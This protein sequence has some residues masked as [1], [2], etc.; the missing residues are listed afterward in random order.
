MA[1][2]QPTSRRARPRVSRKDQRCHP[3]LELLETRT[4]LTGTPVP[5][6]EP[7]DSLN[8]A[9]ALGAL[10]NASATPVQGVIGSGAFGAADVD[11]YT[12]TLTNPGHI[13]LSAT[14]D[15]SAN[16]NAVLGLYNNDPGNTFDPGAALDG[17][18]L[19]QQVV[20][21]GG[22]AT[23]DR[24]LAAGTY[25]IAVSGKGNQYFY[26][27]MPGSGLDGQTGGYLLQATGTP[28]VSSSVL[29][30]SDF[31][32]VTIH[33]TSGNPVLHS[34]PLV[35]HFDASAP[36]DPGSDVHLFDSNGDDLPISVNIDAATDELQIMPVQALAPDALVPGNN[37]YTVVVYT[38]S[39]DATVLF[40]QSFVVDGVEGNTSAIADD[41]VA[42]AHN[43]GDV[44]DGRIVQ[45]TGA[46]GTDPF[47]DPINFFGDPNRGNPTNQVDLYRFHVGGSGNYALVAE[48]FAGRI[49]SSLHPALTLFRLNADGSVDTLAG[50]FETGNTQ[51]AELDVGQTIPRVPLLTDPAIFANL[52]P[53]DYLL[54]VSTRFNY[55]DPTIGR[56]TGQNGLSPTQLVFDP[57]VS[58][59]GTLGGGSVG[60]YVLNL[61]VQPASFQPGVVSV[62]VTSSDTA[63]AY[64][65]DI[66]VRFSGPVNLQ[67]LAF[68]A[69]EHNLPSDLAAIFVQDANGATFVPRLTSYNPNTFDAHFI[70]LDRLPTGTYQLHLSG[71]AGLADFSGNQL[72]GN[73]LGGDFVD[74]F[75]VTGAPALSSPVPTQ[76]GND[77]VAHAQNLGVVF[78]HEFENQ[79]TLR[80][81][82][83]ASPTDPADSSDFYSFQVVQSL[84]YSFFLRNVNGIVL[85]PDLVD[86]SGNILASGSRGILRVHLDPGTYF[87]R[88][89][90]WDSTT[91]A[92]TTYDLVFSLGTNNE[93]P[94]ALTTGPAPALRLQLVSTVA[95]PVPTAPS[96]ITLPVPPGNQNIAVA[97]NNG[98]S[99]GLASLLPGVANALAAGPV[100]GV[101]SPDAVID[102][103]PT[104]VLLDLSPPT[105]VASGSG[106]GR[107]AAPG[108]AGDDEPDNFFSRFAAALYRWSQR[109][110]HARDLLF[111]SDILFRS[112]EPGGIDDQ[113]PQPAPDDPDDGE[114]APLRQVDIEASVPSK[115]DNCSDADLV[116]T[117]VL[118]LTGLALRSGPHDRKAR[119]LA[120]A[121]RSQGDA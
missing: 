73:T 64:P 106:T 50:N 81:D 70:L 40:Q 88:V 8:H 99:S 17:H 114:A 32:A 36:I 18:R 112:P 39:T 22:A 43:L 16:L 87:L 13:H 118:G 77:D 52:T 76:L 97:A 65:T 110:L 68:A 104:V 37:P 71:A 98:A 115:V 34:S 42:N 41:T 69:F 5:E 59:S 10:D 2:R 6:I 12:F 45:A 28:P 24:D 67:Q 109:S 89:R 78:G 21:A 60:A 108:G 47:Y 86:A 9:Q 79:F 83:T 101:R 33:D 53:G 84:N 119:R 107:G 19:M 102:L 82:F 51:T 11:W 58:H 105:V 63:G 92:S 72:A 91:A 14:A 61:R 113:D 120:Q 54:A 25:F 56:H 20:G 74:T 121:L 75:T 111:S 35:M 1:T 4:L 3:G 38:D 31:D 100:G 48:A 15:D 96:I 44:T 66:D 23:L 62:T 94:T 7:N 29:L 80:R 90:G 30:A 57:T 95:P 46:I 26:P 116:W 49:G 93:N 117:G 27:L 103:G 55:A 85:S